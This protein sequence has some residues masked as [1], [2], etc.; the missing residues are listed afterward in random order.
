[1]A[2]LCAASPWAAAPQEPKLPTFE[3]FAASTLATWTFFVTFMVLVKLKDSLPRASRPGSSSADSASSSCM[4]MLMVVSFWLSVGGF[5]YY[6]Y[7]G[8]YWLIEMLWTA[9]PSA[10]A[11]REHQLPTFE[12][13]CAFTTAL[14]TFT[15][16]V[17]L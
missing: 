17:N 10:M 9:S 6:G 2:M 15:V 8:C 3:V 12:V 4:S 1:M 13:F 16:F 11:P 14:C 7:F 5:R